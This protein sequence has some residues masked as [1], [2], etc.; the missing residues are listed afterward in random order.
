MDQADQ[1][2]LDLCAPAALLTLSKGLSIRADVAVA[3]VHNMNSGEASIQ[4]TETHDARDASGTSVKVPSGFAILIPIFRDGDS[5]ALLARLRHRRA[6]TRIEWAIQ[7]HRSDLAL[8]DAIKGCA[9]D[10]AEKT[11]LPLFYGSPE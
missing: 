11:G 6:G 7:L 4:F 1:L 10:A 3:A 9:D 5:Y 2:G 8:R